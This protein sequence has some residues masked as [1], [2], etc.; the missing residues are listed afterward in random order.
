MI[1][2]F[3]IY[4]FVIGL[5]FGSFALAVADRSQ[6]N[7]NW[8]T[9]RSACDNCHKNLDFFDL[10]PVLSYL[11]TW[12][13][14]RHCQTKLSAL[15]PLVEL[16]MGTVFLSSYL[17]TLD[18]TGLISIIQLLLWLLGLVLMMILVII[19]ARTLTLPY[20][21]LM[22]L[23]GLSALYAGSELFRQE[24]VAH[25]LVMLVASLAVSFGVFLFLY[26]FSRGK[27]IGDSD[28]LLGIAMGLFLADPYLS[29][30][31]IV[32]A[33]VLGLIY[34]MSIVMVRKKPLKNLKIPFGP[35]LII[36]LFIAYTCGQQ[37]IDW[38]IASVLF[39]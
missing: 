21:F 14:C 1:I 18:N 34:G 2:L 33:S 28:V 16:I 31:A 24:S 20:K 38:Y 13:R 11:F 30:L 5:A 17:L 23:I 27:W 8:V 37:I 12:G 7:K 26:L 4:T 39:L 19:D 3:G 10:V 6:K 35:F 32:L 25:Y 9:G 29:W 36:G 22:P 15:Y